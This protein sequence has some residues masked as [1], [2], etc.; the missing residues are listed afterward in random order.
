MKTEEL[1]TALQS[2]L[3]GYA[4]NGKNLRTESCADVF[5]YTHPEK[6][7]LFLKVRNT[8]LAPQEAD[9]LAEKTAI[10]WLQGKLNVPEV[11]CLYVEGGT[12]YLL[13]T[14][15]A[16]LSGVHPE[17]MKDRPNLIREFATGLRQI[18]SIDIDSC[19]LDWRMER[20]ISW[21]AGLIEMGA[22]DTQIPP[23]KTR[24][25]LR[26]ELTRIMA[27]LPKEE[28]L[29]FIHGDYCLPNIVIR[30]GRLSGVID[31]GYAGVGDRYLDFVS[32]AYTIRRNLGPEWVSL[33]FE[34]YGLQKLDE[35]KL[36][37]YR[38]VHDFIE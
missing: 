38:R 9:L 19:P 30:N 29:V 8:Q 26:V 24:A 22:L 1:P 14:Q 3:E 25:F 33:F 27:G 21:A 28:D 17:T 15:I 10:S 7:V 34:E 12:Q 6:E 16:G 20:Y 18:H 35:E 37:A 11:V 32:A 5:L 31:W 36:M 13:M 23:G 2:H 4:S